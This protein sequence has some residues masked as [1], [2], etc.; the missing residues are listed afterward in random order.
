MT[1]KRQRA[2]AEAS[3]DV[4]LAERRQHGR[5]TRDAAQIVDAQGNIGDPL[6]TESLLARL[7]GAGEITR[8]EHDAG[9]EFQRLFRLA[10]LDELR[11]ADMG[12]VVVTGSGGYVV[13]PQAEW[14]RGRIR[15]AIKAVGGDTSAAGLACWYLLGIELSMSE[16]ASRPIWLGRRPLNREAAKGALVGALGMLDRFFES[17]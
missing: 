11:A 9:K 6:W 15:E 14:A 4:V 5:V 7:E 2:S 10:A 12:R 17:R 16:F 8:A 13:T 1:R 3:D